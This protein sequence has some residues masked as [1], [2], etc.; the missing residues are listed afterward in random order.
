MG[1]CCIFPWDLLYTSE[2]LLISLDYHQKVSGLRWFSFAHSTCVCSY[3][4]VPIRSKLL[5]FDLHKYNARMRNSVVLTQIPASR[6]SQ[7][8]WYSS[9]SSAGFLAVLPLS[10]LFVKGML[11]KQYS[12]FFYE[13]IWGP[14][15]VYIEVTTG[16]TITKFFRILISSQLLFSSVKCTI[17]FPI[18][19]SILIYFTHYFSYRSNHSLHIQKQKLPTY[20]L[21]QSLCVIRQNGMFSASNACWFFTKNHWQLRS[22]II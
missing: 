8:H 15:F 19:N 16:S 14:T 7:T 10:A 2:I 9:F 13:R 18:F 4:E 6:R 12:F 21:K 20:I 5:N 3:N 11:F 22:V 17:L 1:L